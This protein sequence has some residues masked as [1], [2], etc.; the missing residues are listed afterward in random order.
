MALKIG[1]KVNVYYTFTGSLDDM[2]HYQ[3]K[4]IGEENYNGYKDP[5]W[6][7]SFPRGKERKSN[8]LKQGRFCLST[9]VVRYS[10]P[11]RTGFITALNDAVD[12]QKLYV[13]L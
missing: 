12:I 13:N 3:G 11:Y 4:I 9:S 5:E 1:D 2:E 6:E 7:V 10:T 8:Y